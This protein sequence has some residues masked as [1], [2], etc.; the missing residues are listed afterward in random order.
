MDRQEADLSPYNK[1][2]Y[3]KIRAQREAEEAASHD[4][5][6][7]SPAAGQAG[8]GSLEPGAD[9]HSAAPTPHE[10]P[11]T[12]AAH[13]VPA[14]PA[15]PPS[16]AGSSAYSRDRAAARYRG[17][18]R[19]ESGAGQSAMAAG[20]SAVSA[21]RDRFSGGVGR[22]RVVLTVLF[23]LIGVF[24]IASLAWFA[25]V[26]M[27]MRPS[28]DVSRSV[29]STSFGQPYYV[30]LLGSDSR[31]E[32]D[33]VARADSIML[34][35]VDESAKQ[36][37]FI[38]LPRDLRVEIPGHGYGKLNSAL[39]YGGFS[40][41]IDAASSLAGVPISYYAVVYFSGFKKL[42][43]DLGGVTVEV[44]EGTY[45]KGTWVPA[46]KKS[47]INGKQ[48]LVLA[49]CRHGNPPDQGAYAAGDFQRTKNQ[50]NLMKAIVKK[51][52]SKNPVEVPGL[53]LSISECVE[54]NMP[55]HKLA[56]MAVSMRGMSSKHM[57]SASV[58]CMSSYIDGI[59]Y[60]LLDEAG[61]EAM[62]KRVE[63]GKD[64]SK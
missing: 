19:H 55:A 6:A 26:S 7:H 41:A 37:T 15:T 34:C 35:R 33:D 1:D 3:A 9:E 24:L 31:S 39:T 64:P 58:P 17:M 13:E 54:T 56:L 40:G 63:A 20:G 59:S 29:K 2:K 45:Y 48:A 52:L 60:Q 23:V 57:Y 49:R 30:L 25:L 44:P 8:V 16:N 61:W 53:V 36:V 27:N 62:M 43:D 51:A 32:A 18:K 14:T 12:P 47:K 50:R 4:G 28:E 22:R 21:L 46:G 5:S 38:S 10:V 42:V 11:A